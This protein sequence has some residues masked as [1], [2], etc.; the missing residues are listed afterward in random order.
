MY[1]WR[2]T[3]NSA[4]FLVRCSGI[5]ASLILNGKEWV[6]TTPGE[7]ALVPARHSS[8][9]VHVMSKTFWPHA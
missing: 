4:M 6:G 7:G 9:R 1:E 5:A 3:P 8:F 2:P